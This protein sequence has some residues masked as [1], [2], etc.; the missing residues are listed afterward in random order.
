MQSAIGDG[1][2]CK[3]D[4]MREFGREYASGAGREMF[5]QRQKSLLKPFHMPLV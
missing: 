2:E 1:M 5:A 3:E 4:K